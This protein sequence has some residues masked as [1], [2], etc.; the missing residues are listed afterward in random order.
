MGW[1]LLLLL[2]AAVAESAPLL[3]LLLWELQ[4]VVDELQAKNGGRRVQAACAAATTAPRILANSRGQTRVVVAVVVVVFVWV[5]CVQV[6]FSK[7]D[8][9]RVCVVEF[10]L[11]IHG[12]DRPPCCN[13][14]RL[15]LPPLG[16]R[17]P[18]VP[19]QLRRQPSRRRVFVFFQ[20]RQELWPV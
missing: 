3:L 19:G 9:S 8:W 20:R 1:L 6:V 4:K 16:P 5:E 18:V 10:L 7:G 13:R 2:A 15:L 12:R 17:E 11:M 14:R